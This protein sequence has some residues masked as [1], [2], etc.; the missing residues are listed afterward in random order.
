[1]LVPLAATAQ[2]IETDLISTATDSNLVDGWGLTS[3]PASPWWVSNQNTSTST[4]STA[5]GSIVPLVVQIPC[6]SAGSISVPCA[7]PGLYPIAPPFGPTGIVANTFA[8]IG[9][10]LVKESGV[11]GPALFIFATLDGLIVGWNPNVKPTRAEVGARRDGASYTGLAISPGTT[12]PHLYAANSVG[13]I[14]VFDS[15]FKLVNT[16]AADSS[17]GPFTP[18]GIQTIGN[19]LY[20][21]YANPAVQGGTVDVCDLSTSATA[22]DCHR[23]AASFQAPFVLDSPW[24]LALAPDKFGQLGHQLLV[25]NLASGHIVALNPNTGS[26]VGMLHLGREKLFTV[27]GLWALEFGHGSANNGATNQLF[28]SAGPP[29]PGKAIFSSGLFGVIAPAP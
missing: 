7:I 12:N 21:T 6:I 26:F 5:N 29:A 10:F 14:D 25:G 19:N 24:G 15:T 11:S 22:P 2:Y 3:F 23:L 18:Y 17:P 9:A 13:G 27:V 1:V 4:L 16:F 28:F 20:V 8:G